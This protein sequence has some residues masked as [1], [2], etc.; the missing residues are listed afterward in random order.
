MAGRQLRSSTAFEKCIVPGSVALFLA[1]QGA[2]CSLPFAWALLAF[3]SFLAAL[4]GAID[5]E[6]PLS[7]IEKAIA[8]AFAGCALSAAF[9]LDLQRSLRL[10][11]PMF[12][13]LLMWILITRDRHA[14]FGFLPLAIGLAIA[15]SA[16]SAL[17]VL[18]AESHPGGTPA[19][20]VIDAGSAWLVVPNDVAWMACTLPLI[21]IVARGRSVATLFV[22]L[23]TFLALCVLVR[24]RTAAFVSVMVA[25]A[26]LASSFSFQ[27]WRS[28]IRWMAVA[29]AT[30]AA[31]AFA[32]FGVA[33]M[34]ARLQLWGAA[35]SIFLDHPWAGV[36]IHNFVLAYRPY[37][38]PHAELI[39]ARITPWPHNLILEIAAE[40]GL[41]GS[42]AILFLV[43]CLVRRG[44]VLGRTTLAPMQ[45][46][47]LA[48]LF[49]MLLLALVEASLLRQWV[50]LLGTA[51]CALLII[52]VKPSVHGKASDEGQRLDN[53]VA[54]R[55]L[56]RTS[57]R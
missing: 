56:R 13:S 54:I 16:Q 9:G 1:L 29:A 37:L 32:V 3:G 20:W 23:V 10:S 21:A 5:F 39:D 31:V 27:R 33:S 51:M 4:C 50:W 53:D 7:T 44:V 11:V 41:I 36:G 52:D 22:L 14:R 55:R 28:S 12:A 35:W 57:R 45:R 17:L 43:G 46:A 18:A 25:I 40:C 38:P 30:T 42:I 15:A 26:F 24:S 8:V 6:R 49:G 48:G 2:D 34:R 19:E 47:A